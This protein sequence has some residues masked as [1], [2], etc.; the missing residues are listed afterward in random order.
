MT[1]TTVSYSTTPTGAVLGAGA[2][3]PPGGGAGGGLLDR[4]TASTALLATGALELQAALS[5]L[6]YLHCRAP[7]QTARVAAT[8]WACCGGV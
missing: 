1:R 4:H 3:G 2:R 6:I 5:G 8:A 7:R